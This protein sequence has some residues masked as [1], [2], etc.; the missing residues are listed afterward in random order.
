MLLIARKGEY[1]RL[2]YLSSHN[3]F[4]YRKVG[5]ADS[6]GDM[7]NLCL[8]LYLDPDFDGREHGPSSMSIE[9]RDRGGLSISITRDTEQ[10]VA[11]PRLYSRAQT[12][13]ITLV[14][15]VEEDVVFFFF[16]FFLKLL[17]SIIDNK[18]WTHLM[19]SGERNAH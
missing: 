4:T 11:E 8:E 6:G 1:Q 18:L 15:I 12:T 3:S 10:G 5:N 19:P 17:P 7:V 2:Q 13:L 14:Q 16:F 9:R